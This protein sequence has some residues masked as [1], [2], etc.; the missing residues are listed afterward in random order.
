MKNELERHLILSSS[1]FLA[2]NFPTPVFLNSPNRG[3]IE[4]ASG[5]IF[6]INK[7]IAKT[8]AF[9]KLSVYNFIR[10]L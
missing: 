1:F 3:L 5:Q 4:S 8:L 2:S 9:M 7:L 6:P 10:C